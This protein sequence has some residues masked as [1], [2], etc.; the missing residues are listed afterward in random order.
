VLSYPPLPGP[1]SPFVQGNYTGCGTAIAVFGNLTVD[2]CPTR[3]GITP[4]GGQVQTWVYSNSAWVPQGN[5][6]NSFFGYDPHMV[7]IAVYEDVVV[8]GSDQD[9]D[10]MTGYYSGSVS[11]FRFDFS[12]GN[13]N[14]L[15]TIYVSDLF[16]NSTKFDLYFGHSVDIFGT[17]IVVGFP[18]F[19]SGSGA[20]VV[21]DETIPDKWTLTQVIYESRTTYNLAL[22]GWSVSIF[23]DQ[24]VI[25]VPSIF[26]SLGYVIAYQKVAFVWIFQWETALSITFANVGFDVDNDDSN[27]VFYLEDSS[28][29]FVIV[30]DPFSAQEAV[31]SRPYVSST[32]NSDN[33][34]QALSIRNDTLIVGAHAADGL[35]LQSGV[36]FVY[37]RT[38]GVPGYLWAY[39]SK[40]YPTD[41]AND[42]GIQFGYDVAVTTELIIGTGAPKWDNI[43]YE[44]INLGAVYM[45]ECVPFYPCPPLN[46]PL[47]P[48]TLPL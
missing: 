45:C 2:I 31:L 20:V 17:T 38:P 32:G 10:P 22:L 5:Y 34:G 1:G 7:S 6:Q 12:T 36:A 27:V 16:V 18:Q 33:F 44:S 19:G 48:P 39:Q 13:L 37:K 25:G 35:F 41:L 29:P 21:L 14:L 24:I 46:Q 43:G 28:N 8:V 11:I 40:K 42:D 23:G 3:I 47:F 15:Q 9:L 4:F 26:S 30:T